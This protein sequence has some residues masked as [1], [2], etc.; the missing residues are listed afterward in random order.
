M[1]FQP[2]PLECAINNPQRKQNSAMQPECPTN[3]SH[4]HSLPTKS[5]APYVVRLTQ[6]IINLTFHSSPATLVISYN[7]ALQYLINHSPFF[8][9]KIV[10]E[11]KSSLLSSCI[12]V[13]LRPLSSRT[14]YRL[15]SPAKLDQSRHPLLHL[16]FA[17][18]FS[19]ITKVSLQQIKMTR[20]TSILTNVGLT[21]LLITLFASSA[22]ASVT[23][24]NVTTTTVVVNGT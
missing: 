6:N 23:G 11:T 12:R 14:N 17:T 3:M 8:R 24:S 2:Q 13:S 5:K 10:P 1:H 18:K 15:Q 16:L 7:C 19:P 22:L 21:L 20:S 4:K 9:F